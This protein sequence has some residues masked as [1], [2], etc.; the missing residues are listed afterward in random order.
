M[1]KHVYMLNCARS[2]TYMP[3]KVLCL[4]FATVFFR[5]NDLL[6]ANCESILFLCYSMATIMLKLSVSCLVL[7]SYTNTV[8]LLAGYTSEVTTER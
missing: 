2:D 4:Y 7:T 5:H 8:Q 6:V 3:V 1:T